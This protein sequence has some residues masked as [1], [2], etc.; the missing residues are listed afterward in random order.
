MKREPILDELQTTPLELRV[1]YGPQSGSRLTLSLGEYQL[2]SSD[3]CTI[4]LT[5]PRIEGLHAKLEIEDGQTSVTPL[6][7]KINDT[8]GNP[9]EETTTLAL[10]MPIEIGGVWISID[11]IDADWPDPVEVAPISPASPITHP[12]LHEPVVEV[13]EAPSFIHQFIPVTLRARLGLL[14][15]ISAFLIFII[16]GVSLIFSL[17]KNDSDNPKMTVTQNSS[18]EPLYFNEIRSKIFPLTEKNSIK[19]T[20]NKQGEVVVRGYVDT[21]A[22]KNKITE[23]VHQHAPNPIIQIYAENEILDAAKNLI[24]QKEDKNR[25]KLS[26]D[27]INN[28][29]LKISG[30]VSSASARDEVIEQFKSTIPGVIEVEGSLLGPEEIAFR[31]ETELNDAGLSKR[32]QIISRQPDFVLRGKLTE[33]EIRTW[34]NLVQGFYTN[35]GN[36][37]PIRATISQIQNKPP[38]N[39]ETIVGGNTPFV[40]TASGQRVGK[41]GNINGN[42][43]SIVRDNEI[44]FDG[45]ERFRIGR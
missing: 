13:T 33:S 37:L 44:I 15:S 1:L 17:Q 35:Y 34:E 28:G 26:V 22:I 16:C 9:I 36:L 41:G 25:S 7:G 30:S 38:V 5:G 39:V 21:T 40:V 23:I 14:I 11:H 4:I 8:L 29:I 27:G 32:F 45:N 2:G 3:E 20:K 19:V 12:P 31:F 42:V 18:G 6:D 24:D 10:G 43:L